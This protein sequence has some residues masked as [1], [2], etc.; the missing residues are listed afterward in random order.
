MVHSVPTKWTHIVLNYI[1]PNDGQGIRI[2]FDG[3]KVKSDTDKRARS[4]SAG[5]GRIVVGRKFTNQDRDY[6]SVEM[7]ELI[8]FN[9]ALR[10]DNV[11][12]IYNSV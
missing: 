2:Y 1:G 11:Q 3:L 9:A 8:F 12:S 6:V 4:Y 10:S 5:N 7:D